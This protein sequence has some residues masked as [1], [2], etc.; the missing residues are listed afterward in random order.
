MLQNTRVK[1]FTF[2]ELL[3]ENQQGGTTPPPTP[4]RLELT[5]KKVV[6]LLKG[7]N[8]VTKGMLLKTIYLYLEYLPGPKW[9]GP[10][11]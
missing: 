1:V 3:R 9:M 4:P 8:I 5:A 2:F 7:K 6:A 11:G 10:S